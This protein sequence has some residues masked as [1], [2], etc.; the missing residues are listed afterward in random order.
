MFRPA[1]PGDV[2]SVPIEE[3]MTLGQR[4]LPDFILF[5]VQKYNICSGSPNGI[6][7]VDCAM[8]VL[9]VKNCRCVYDGR[10]IDPVSGGVFFKK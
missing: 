7:A 9:A 3:G 6:V 4:A 1:G 5:I 2:F 8:G 10:E